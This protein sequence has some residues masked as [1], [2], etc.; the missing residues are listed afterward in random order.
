MSEDLDDIDETLAQIEGLLK[1]TEETAPV[2]VES[3]PAAPVQVKLPPE[4]PVQVNLPAAAPVQVNL[5]SAAAKPPPKKTAFKHSFANFLKQADQDENRIIAMNSAGERATVWTAVSPRGAEELERLRVLE[6]E[7]LLPIV[8]V[9][10]RDD[11]RVRLVSREVTEPSVPEPGAVVTLEDFRRYGEAMLRGIVSLHEVGFRHGRLGPGCLIEGSPPLLLNFWE[12]PTDTEDLVAV[13]AFLS[14]LAEGALWS[15]PYAG[16]IK[17]PEKFSSA[18]EMLVEFQKL[19][20]ASVEGAERLELPSEKGFTKEQQLDQTVAFKAIS[21]E[22]LAS[23]AE[24]AESARVP[25]PEEQKMLDSA[26]VDPQNGNRE[27]SA[28]E[29]SSPGVSSSKASNSESTPQ[30]SG[31]RPG[32]GQPSLDADYA[33]EAVTGGLRLVWK[34]GEW[35]FLKIK[36]L[37]DDARGKPPPE[38]DD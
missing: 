23:Y 1:E 31:G 29:E 21:K 16:L 32:S 8:E 22:E 3:P 25:T 10:V 14:E 34:L 33:V 5:P 2:S 36:R 28:P 6:L 13:C 4:A 26:A 24:T 9:V 17:H 12:E 27:A 11:S 35:I 15:D 18:R 20:G 7:G 37:V 38:D 19:H 30:G